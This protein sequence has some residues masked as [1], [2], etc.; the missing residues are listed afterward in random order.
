MG[1]GAGG[2]ADCAAA[3]GGGLNWLRHSA[4]L[5]ATASLLIA[6]Q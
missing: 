3:S 5:R 2:A 4:K 6:T 1:A